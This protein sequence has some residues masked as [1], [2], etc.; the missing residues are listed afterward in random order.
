[1][2]DPLRFAL[3]VL[4]AALVC[5]PWTWLDLQASSAVGEEDS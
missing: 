1:M 3:A 4:L 2:A 5:L